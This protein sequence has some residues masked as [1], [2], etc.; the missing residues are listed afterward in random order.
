LVRGVEEQLG[1][2]VRAPVRVVFEDL[3]NFPL[4]VFVEFEVG[5]V[6]AFCFGG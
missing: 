1:D 2:A 4:A 3:G 6:G 5:D